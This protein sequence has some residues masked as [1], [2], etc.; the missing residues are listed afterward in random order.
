[1]SAC[2]NGAGSGLRGRAR[3]RGPCGRHARARAGRC[4]AG[5]L[6]RPTARRGLACLGRARP[7]PVSGQGRRTAF[8]GCRC[9]QTPKDGCG[10]RERKGAVSR[11]PSREPAQGDACEP[12]SSVVSCALGRR[13][14]SALAADSQ[15]ADRRAWDHTKVNAG[16]GRGDT[17]E[18]R[19]G[20]GACGQRRRDAWQAEG[21]VVRPLTVRQ[22]ETHRRRS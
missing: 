14:N 6:S 8:T 4:A 22:Q 1:M 18:A 17:E 7:T 16:A 3:Q 20:I 10:R 5:G 12:G 21:H 13:A 9:A 15:E 19:V 2:P 11:R